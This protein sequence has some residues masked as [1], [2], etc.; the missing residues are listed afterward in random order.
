MAQRLKKKNEHSEEDKE[1]AQ[2]RPAAAPKPADSENLMGE[3][4]GNVTQPTVGSFEYCLKKRGRQ[5]SA[6]TIPTRRAWG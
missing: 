5:L 2:Q 4:R 6:P 3:A 1:E